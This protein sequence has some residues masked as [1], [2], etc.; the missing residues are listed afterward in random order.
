MFGGGLRN[1]PGAKRQGA[2]IINFKAITLA[3]KPIFDKAFQGRRYENAHFSFG[4]LFMWQKA[5]QIEW[6]VWEDV[7]LVKAAWEGT[8]F[9][10]PPFGADC[11]FGRAVLRLEDYFKGAGKPFMLRGAETFMLELLEQQL[12]G[13]F[14]SEADR[15]NFDYL[16]LGENLRELRGRKFHKKKNHA[17]GFRQSYPDYEYRELRQE[18]A[19]ETV[20]FL[21]E[22][23]R[24][25]NCKKGDSLYCERK[26]LTVGLQN[27][28]ALGLVGG[29]IY[30]NGEMKA[31]TFGE[32]LNADTAV[33]HA[34][35]ADA[36]L[37][38]VYTAICQDYCQQAWAD[39]MYINRE[40]DMGEEN[41]R[42]AKLAYQPVRLVEKHVLTRV[43]S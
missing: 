33:V 3:D 38:G 10:L 42:K 35:K 6:A 26:A 12:P 2:G 39:M 40:E 32:R 24:Q 43:Q 20:A 27:F 29:A 30:L 8:D 1:S 25:R 41:I 36:E 34:E 37:R 4:N 9:V 14:S 5:Y 21:K 15:D 31:V 11:D 23:C 18:M 28:T 17:N 7:L 22:W 16:Y 19:E 13:V